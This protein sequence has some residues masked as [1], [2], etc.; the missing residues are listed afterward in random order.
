MCN[1]NYNRKKA[2]QIL[3]VLFNQSVNSYPVSH[4]AYFPSMSD[5]DDCVS[6]RYNGNPSNS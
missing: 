4:A 5:S 2:E 1:L 6:Q 3:P